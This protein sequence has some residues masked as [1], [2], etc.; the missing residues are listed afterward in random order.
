MK[1]PSSPKPRE[2][3]IFS[4]AAGL[5]ALNFPF[6]EIFNAGKNVYGIPV[7][8]AYLFLAWSL[9]IFIVVLFLH[10]LCQDPEQAETDKEQRKNQE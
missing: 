2:I 9:L 7:L 1:T 10:I 3:W 4:L 6:I 8:I 5:L